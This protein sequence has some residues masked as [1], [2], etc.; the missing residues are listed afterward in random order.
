MRS[1]IRNDGINNEAF[2]ALPQ[3]VS[4]RHWR[5]ALNVVM[6]KHGTINRKRHMVRSRRLNNAGESG[7]DCRPLRNFKGKGNRPF[8]RK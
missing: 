5:I 4:C 1:H 8:G 3:G 7:C 6:R 2:I